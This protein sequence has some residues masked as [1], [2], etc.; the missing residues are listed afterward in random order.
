MGSPDVE[1]WRTATRPLII[2]CAA[3]TN[4]LRA[5]LRASNLDQLFDVA[6]LPAN[7]HFRPELIIPQLEPVIADAVAAGRSVFIGYADCGTGGLLDAMLARYPGVQ[8][9][10]GAHCYQFFVGE[11]V[12]AQMQEAELGTFYLTDFLVKHFDALVWGSLGLERAPELRDMYFANYTR[13][14][15]L[16]Q[17]VN[18]EL[19]VAARRAA[20][21]LGLAFEHTHVGQGGLAQPVN[22]WSIS[23]RKAA[24]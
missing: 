15:Y 1:A 17:T 13:V 8:R 18:P 21:R 22:E 23:L 5:V 16:S 11:T 9:L 24:A 7:L 19:I 20:D 3:L 6:Y 14:M 12:F 2:A 10:P 4:D